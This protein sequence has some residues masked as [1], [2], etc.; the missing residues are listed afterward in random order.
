MQLLGL[1]VALICFCE[2]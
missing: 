2:T 1:P